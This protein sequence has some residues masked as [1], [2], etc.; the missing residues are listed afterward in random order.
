M[1]WRDPAWKYIPASETAKPGYLERRFAE[2]RRRQKLDAQERERE[3]LESTL[4][5]APLQSDSSS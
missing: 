1:S 2:I 4:N 5:V 3:E